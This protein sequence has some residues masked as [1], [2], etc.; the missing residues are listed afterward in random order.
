MSETT[1]ATQNQSRYSVHFT[2]DATSLSRLQLHCLL[3]VS[4][5]LVT[6]KRMNKVLDDVDHMQSYQ[7]RDS[8]SDR[9][10]YSR[11]ANR[12]IITIRI[13]KS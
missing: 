10:L 11:I 7:N 13:V 4:E 1:K 8:E 6:S 12:R 3:L 5:A 2:G 9:N